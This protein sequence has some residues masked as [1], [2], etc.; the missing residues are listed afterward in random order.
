MAADMGL[1][2]AVATLVRGLAV[3][4]RRHVRR[5][6]RGAR[7]QTTRAEIPWQNLLNKSGRNSLH[8]GEH[9]SLNL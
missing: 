1:A 9:S 2:S 7:E 8:L 3:F 4:V 5:G 6:P